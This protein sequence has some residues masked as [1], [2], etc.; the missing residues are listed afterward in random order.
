MTDEIARLIA[1]NERE[2]S[3][4]H[5]PATTEML[6]VAAERLALRLPDQ[7]VEFLD[8]YGQG[9]LDGFEILGVL[10]DGEMPFVEVTM[11]YRKLGLPDD[12]CVIENCDEWLECVD[13]DDGKVVSWYLDGEIVPDFDDFDDFLLDRVE[14][15]IDAM[16]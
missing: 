8:S 12:L 10:P 4:T 11:E 15:A 7:Y 2:H 1:A 13:C 5:I 6:E 16:S 9:G 14:N 3:F